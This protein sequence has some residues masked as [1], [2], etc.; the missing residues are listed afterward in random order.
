[1]HPMRELRG[2]YETLR[3]TL[4]EDRRAGEYLRI[5]LTDQRVTPESAQYLRNL[6]ERRESVL[7]E[8]CSEYQAFAGTAETLSAR[9]LEQ[10]SAEE[11]FCDFFTQRAGGE[12]PSEADAA[13]LSR[14]GEL[15]RGASGRDP[16][17]RDVQALLDFVLH[18]EVDA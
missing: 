3:Q 2:D 17:E 11:L 14:A 4:S 16:E 5:V 15:L 8:L 7:M 6:C 18:Q 13:L 10:R 1:M 12:P 9:A